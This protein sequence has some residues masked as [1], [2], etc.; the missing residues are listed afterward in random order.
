MCD[1]QHTEPNNAVFDLSP[2]E[3]G[4]CDPFERR[5]VLLQIAESLT[6]RLEGRLQN[7]PLSGWSDRQN[8]G[9]ALSASSFGLW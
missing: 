7:A 3:T 6:L 5:P 8:E 2:F 9:D 4:P 1:L